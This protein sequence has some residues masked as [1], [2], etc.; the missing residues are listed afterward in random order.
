MKWK[1]LQDQVSIILQ[2]YCGKEKK[3]NETR[4]KETK[5]RFKN[6]RERKTNKQTKTS[7]KKERKKKCFSG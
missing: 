5:K 4:N 7:A 6:F 3:K 2:L 1:T